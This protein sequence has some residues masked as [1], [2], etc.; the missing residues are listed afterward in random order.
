MDNY[1][2]LQDVNKN[3]NQVECLINQ[4]GSAIITKNGKPMFVISKYNPMDLKLTDNEIVE[5]VG[6][7]I[8]NKHKKAF[9]ELGKWYTIKKKYYYYTI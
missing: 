4:F 1:I 6:K 2:S 5:I 8:L 3:F 9:E 7:R